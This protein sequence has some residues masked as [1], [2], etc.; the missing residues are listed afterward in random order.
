MQQKIYDCF[1]YF[2]EDQ[3]LKLR[4]ET[5][6][7]SVDYFVIC[8]ATRTH[9]GKE[10]TVNFNFKKFEKYKSKIRYLLIDSYP[11][12]TDDPWVYENYQRNYLMNGLNDASDNDWILISDLDEIP[13]PDSISS[14]NPAV[15][16]SGSFHQQVFLYFLNNRVMRGASPFIW[17]LP[18]ITTL[19]VLRDVF[20]SPQEVRNYRGK[21]IF[22]GIKKYFIRK[23][24][25]AIDDGG[26]HFT[27]MGGVERI[28]LKMESMAHQELNKPEF[29]D[30]KIIEEK[31]RGGGDIFGEGMSVPGGV[32]SIVKIDYQHMPK[33][34]VDHQ[35]EFSEIILKP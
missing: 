8:E 12:E 15:Y 5:L 22:R 16:L 31:I 33:Y 9:T 32:S 7:E 13:N 1:T 23:K 27:W 20:K 18:K 25:Q 21:G 30:P 6:W 34:L 24:N 4:F 26:W 28:L 11:F 10:K 19:K 3:L 14:F 17:T 35:Q 2:N 29:R